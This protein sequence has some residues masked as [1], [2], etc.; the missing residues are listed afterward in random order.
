MD[1]LCVFSRW[2]SQCRSFVE[3]VEGFRAE[4]EELRDAALARQSGL[5]REMDDWREKLDELV[6][7]LAVLHRKWKHL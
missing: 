2:D 1:N 6:Y 4:L 5:V 7:D 3:S